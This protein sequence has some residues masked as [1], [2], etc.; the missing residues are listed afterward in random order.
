MSNSNWKEKYAEHHLYAKHFKNVIIQ[1]EENLA[2]H[3]TADWLKEKEQIQEG[4]DDLLGTAEDL[5]LAAIASSQVLDG[6]ARIANQMA[7]I[8]HEKNKRGQTTAQNESYPPVEPAAKK[9]PAKKT[10]KITKTVV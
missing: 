7:Q 2:P 4:I 9:T 5:L 10:A 8:E 1:R 3:E 6:A